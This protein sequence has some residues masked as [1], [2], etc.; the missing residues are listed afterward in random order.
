MATVRAATKRRAGTNQRRRDGVDEQI[1]E[2][3]VWRDDDELETIDQEGSSRCSWQQSATISTGGEGPKHN[4]QEKRQREWSMHK[5]EGGVLEM[6]LV[7]ILLVRVQGCGLDSGG[8]TRLDGLDARGLQCV[9][10][11][12]LGARLA[13]AIASGFGP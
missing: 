2:G 9:A 8:D 10:Q 6:G 12:R 7:R 13:P 4:F 11:L 3:I 1:Q 5:R